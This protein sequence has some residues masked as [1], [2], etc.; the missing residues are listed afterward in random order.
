VRIKQPNR[1]NLQSNQSVMTLSEDISSLLDV[2]PDHDGLN[3][4]SCL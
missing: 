1:E 3:F 2:I 4:E